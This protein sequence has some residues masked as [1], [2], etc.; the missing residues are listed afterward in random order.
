MSVGQNKDYSTESEA[1]VVAHA[2]TL[3]GRTLRDLYGDDVDPVRGKGAFGQL[4]ELVHFGYEPN[5]VPGPDFRVAR[6]ELKATGAERKSMGWRAKERLVLSNI[7]YRGLAEETDFRAS[8]F[9]LKNA[10]LLIVVYHWVAGQGPSDYRVVGVGVVE[11]DLLDPSDRAI[12]EDDWEKIRLAVIQGR[13]H[14][15]S[16]ADTNYLKATRKGAGTGRDDRSQPNSSIPAPNRAYSFKQSFLTRLIQPF[17]AAQPGPR[18]DEASIVLDARQLQAKTFDDLVLDR[19]RR[20]TG[21]TVEE[22]VAVVDPTLNRQAKGFYADLARRML[23]V[24][25]RR[26]EEF[27]KADVVMKI[28]RVKGNGQPAEAMSFPAFRYRD[29]ASQTWMESDLRELLTKR[30]LFVFFREASGTIR[31]HHATFWAMPE[32]LLDGEVRQVWEDTVDRI[33]SGRSER[34]PGSSGSSVLHVRPHARNAADTDLTPSGQRLVK[35]SFWLN[36][37]FIGGIFHMSAKAE[38]L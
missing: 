5:T 31:F 25:T 10:R 6:L 37:G 27:E 11:I 21:H 3:V 35:Q 18:A 4:V 7:N 16:E 30:F 29:L 20:F 17:L 9:Y 14:E 33:A 8:T 32:T 38:G 13:A 2:R 24:K 12:I 34:L 15:L 22:I 19:F 1:V 36:R 28:V 26:I 23:D